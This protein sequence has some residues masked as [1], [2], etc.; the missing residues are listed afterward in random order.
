M[1]YTIQAAN[2]K[3][4]DDAQSDLR[5]CCSHMAKAG[6][7]MTWLILVNRLTLSLVYQ[8]TSVTPDSYEKIS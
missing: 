4:A 2:N 1:Y 5:L 7:I 6:F 8:P 3:G